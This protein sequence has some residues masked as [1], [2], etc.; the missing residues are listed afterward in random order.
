MPI[1]NAIL[2]LAAHRYENREPV[3]TG[4]GITSV[5]IASTVDDLLAP[6]KVYA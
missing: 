2:Y 3:V 4:R 5:E 1:R 6:Y